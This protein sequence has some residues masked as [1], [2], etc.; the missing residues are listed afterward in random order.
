MTV[1]AFDEVAD[2]TSGSTSKERAAQGLVFLDDS[3]IVRFASPEAC[4]LLGMRETDLVGHTVPFPIQMG[5]PT[6]LGVDRGGVQVRIEVRVFAFAWKGVEGR[7]VTL[8]DVSER[9]HADEELRAAN[10]RL[11]EE[12]EARNHAESALNL[13]A[14]VFQHSPSAIFITDPQSRIVAVNRAFSE[15]TGYEAYEVLGKTPRILQSGRHDQAFYRAMW[16]NLTSEGH[17]KGEIWNRK[18][19]GKMYC[20]RL[21]IS[22]VRDTDGE[23]KYYIAVFDDR[24]E[25]VIAESRI[26]H[27]AEHDSLT[28]LPNR[29]LFKDRLEHALAQAHR[30][31]ARIALLFLDLDRFKAVN[32]SLGHTIGDR[33][34]V[35]VA[36][37]LQIAMRESDTIARYGGDEFVALAPNVR[38]PED[39]AHIAQKLLEILEMPFQIE[40]HELHTSTSIGVVMYP[41]DGESA[42]TLLKNADTALFAAKE[43][44]RDRFQF[45]TRS[46]NDEAV[47]RLEIETALRRAVHRDE[48]VLYYQAQTDL[49]T[50]RIASIEALL[51]W[52]HPNRGMLSGGEFIEI[53]EQSNLIVQIGRW[54]VREACR[55]SR[56]WRLAGVPVV[57]LAVNISAAQFVQQNFA[58]MVGDAMREFEIEPGQ[59]DIELTESTVMKHVDMAIATLDALKRLGIGLLIDDFGKGY[60]S[61]SYLQKFPI[62]TLKIDQSFVQDAPENPND[63]S[64]VEAIIDMARRLHLKTIAE[65]VETR[66]QYRFLKDRGCDVAQGYLINRPQSAA[67]IEPLLRA[68][69]FDPDAHPAL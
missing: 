9:Q 21:A 1:P 62:D 68:G 17:W 61:L 16:D 59:I 66:E 65:G 57:P 48:F 8:S 22:V 18:K 25:Q 20:E 30:T 3:D 67:D 54:V 27:L 49:K 13:S 51:R 47:Q 31:N 15:L 10:A 12:I 58:D 5:R 29:M 38:S 55:Q 56:A 7:L 64:I 50:G 52:R 4:V 63:A 39:V 36:H 45:F 14:Q 37:R 11:H 46:M 33:M 40:E 42:E 26:R 34:L 35:E 53:A 24:T 41:E 2:D 44:G 23:P 43:A 60:S 19:D 6:V 69:A 28:N 32:D